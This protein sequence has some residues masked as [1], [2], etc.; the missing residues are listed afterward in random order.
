[1][2]VEIAGRVTAGTAEGARAIRERL[3]AAPFLS[4]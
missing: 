3:A 2:I 1:M 4:Q